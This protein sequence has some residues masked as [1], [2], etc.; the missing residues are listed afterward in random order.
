MNL[1]SFDATQFPALD[2]RV[3][4]HRVVYADAP[5]GTQVPASVAAA[6]SDYLLRS[7]A[8][9]RGLFPTSRETDEVIAAARSAAAD[10]LGCD[11]RQIVFG[12]NMT[13]LAFA[14]SR[15]LA[16]DLGPG[17]EIVVTNLD[18]DAN[19]APWV[20]A[21]DDAGAVVRWVDI[22][23]TDCSLDLASLDAALSARTRF[24]AFPL[25]SNAVGTIAAAAEVVRRARGSDATIVADAVHYAPHRGI[26]AEALDVD[27]LFCS[28]YKF[29][30]PHLG[31]MYGR[32][33]L[34][35]SWWPYKVRPSPDESPERW[36]TGT[37]NHEGL[38]GLT[39]CIDYLAS[40]SDA[41]GDRRERLIA[42]M[43]A[44]RV[45]EEELTCAFLTG[46]SKLEDVK[47]FG[48]REPQSAAHRT[49]T[50]ALRI[51]GMHTSEVV[52]RLAAKGVFAW[53][54][55][56]YALAIMERLGLE[57]SGGAVRIG[58]C[59]YHTLDDV[60]YVL[61]CLEDLP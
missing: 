35:D 61:A 32:G 40:L 17:D 53:D 27:V 43:E 15:A 5:G 3:N 11:S 49:P 57:E 9:S 39:A 29:F 10:F 36:E 59:H 14:L 6:M 55:N 21:A 42:A 52:A 2:R 41:V 50:F 24:V 19:I 54:G 4:G 34:L 18:H 60:D 51:P 13:T 45:H 26:D 47:L 12:P 38:A 46:L 22:D 33:D 7:N 20:A 30:G 48:I 28:A 23:P 37:Q 25:A 16:R 44:I 31:V 8:N 56:Y 1:K 58:F